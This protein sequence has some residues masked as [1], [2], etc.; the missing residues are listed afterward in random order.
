[1]IELGIGLVVTAV[2]ILTI[3]PSQF[4]EQIIDFVSAFESNSRIRSFEAGEV[5]SPRYRREFVEKWRASTRY[6][7]L[8]GNAFFSSF[9]IFELSQ[10]GLNLPKNKLVCVVDPTST[11]MVEDTAERL[12]RTTDEF[13][14]ETLIAL[15]A[16]HDANQ[17]QLRVFLCDEPIG[18]RCEILTSGIFLTYYEGEGKYQETDL[19][20]SKSKVYRYHDQELERASGRATKVVDFGVH[21]A[22]T[23]RVRG[24]EA[25]QA[26]LADLGYRGT[27]ADLRT[28]RDQRFDELR[29]QVG[30][31]F[32]QGIG[33]F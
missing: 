25:L 27:L 13:R 8:G 2:V 28:E 21:T 26:L 22:S 10:Q 33:Y 1:M 17:D 6:H 5:P 29:R 18:Y 31:L 24:D 3:N 30:R 23:D 15:T 12:D 9:R 11:R 20:T 19:Y 32:K 16:L 7:Y 4:R 14:H